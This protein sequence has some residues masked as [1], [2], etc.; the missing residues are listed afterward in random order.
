MPLAT[1]IRSVVEAN[2]RGW[3]VEIY[4]LSHGFSE[5]TKRRVIDS[6]PE[7]S[8]LIR[9]V[10]VDLTPFAGLST[11]G[12]ISSAT[13]ARLLIP[14]VLPDGIPRVLYLDA[15]ILVL[16][17]LG[18]IWESNLDGAALGAVLDESLDTHVKMGKTSLP[19]LPSV[20]DY[21]NA[22]VLLI[23]LARWRAERITEKALE[24]LRQYPDSPYSDQDALNVACDGMWKTLD[25]RWNYYQVDLEK[26]LSE[27]SAAQRPGIVHFHGSLKPWIARSLNSNA[28]FYDRFRSRTL[29]ACTA[30]ERLRRI[31]FTIW[32]RLK[33]ALK[34]SIIGRHVWSHLRSRQSDT[35]EVG[36]H[37]SA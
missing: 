15:D 16:D 19:G 6:Q 33:S 9:W 21:F 18:P 22:A 20:R 3:P 29:F 35:P 8:C 13:Y 25:R 36:R 4:V 28:A 1:T 32:S 37:R 5:S 10:P 17:D 24:Y 14:S 26:P 34:R 11:L 23:D 31:P 2:R 7:G 27:L 12:H 30:E